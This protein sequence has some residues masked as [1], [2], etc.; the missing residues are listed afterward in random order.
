MFSKQQSI[1]SNQ[2]WYPRK[3]FQGKK[4]TKEVLKASLPLGLA[5][6]VKDLWVKV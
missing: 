3:F 6:L 1:T 4:P 2:D 5:Y